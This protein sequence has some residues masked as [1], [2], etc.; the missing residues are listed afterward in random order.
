MTGD[1]LPMRLVA[2]LADERR[3]VR[4]LRREPRSVTRRGELLLQALRLLALRLRLRGAALP[5]RRCGAHR[6]LRLLARLLGVLPALLKCMQCCRRLRER[7]FDLL[8]Y[9]RDALRQAVAL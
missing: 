9:R 8:Q 6:L 2:P 1:L 5:L 3:L 4:L 7:R